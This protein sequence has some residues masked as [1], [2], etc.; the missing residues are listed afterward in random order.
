[1]REFCYRT[2]TKE[3]IAPGANFLK[4]HVDKYMK[5]HQG[6]DP[7][8]TG[9]VI[10]LDDNPGGVSSSYSA[11]SLIFYQEVTPASPFRFFIQEKIFL[12]SGYIQ[13]VFGNDWRYLIKI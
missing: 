9:T 13:E 1:M 4:V 7:V 5:N 2:P 10:R 6:T 12:A 8:L 11:L 3:D